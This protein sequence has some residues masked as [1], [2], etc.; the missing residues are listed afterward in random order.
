MALTLFAT[1][2]LNPAAKRGIRRDAF[3][4]RKS[5]RFLGLQ[6]R[7]QGPDLK[8]KRV[9]AVEVTSTTGGS[10][11]TAIESSKKIAFTKIS[12]L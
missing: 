2:M 4:L 9:I 7:I 5:K 8:E 6:K 10:L 12:L 1:A 11:L 3:A